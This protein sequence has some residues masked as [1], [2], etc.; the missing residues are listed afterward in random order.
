MTLRRQS[1][2]RKLQKTARKAAKS[3]PPPRSLALIAASVIGLAAALIAKR[4]LGGSDADEPSTT[5]AAAPGATWAP[6]PVTQE[7]E[8]ESSQP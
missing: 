3:A 8:R 4:F 1:K 6:Q 2:A 5:D 7:S